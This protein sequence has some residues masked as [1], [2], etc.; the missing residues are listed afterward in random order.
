MRTRRPKTTCFELI[1]FLLQGRHL[2]FQLIVAHGIDVRLRNA[3]TERANKHNTLF[4]VIGQSVCL[5][6]PKRM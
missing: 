5:R 3:V 4:A 6:K 1:D 2:L